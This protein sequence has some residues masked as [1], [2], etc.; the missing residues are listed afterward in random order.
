MLGRPTILLMSVGNPDF[1][2]YELS[3][4]QRMLRAAV[5]EL[6]EKEIAPHAADVDEQARFPQEALDALVQAG[7]HAVHIPEEY[8]G[9]GADAISACIVVEEVARAC[10]SSALIP[11]VNKLGTQ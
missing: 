3:D 5:R 10:G 4:E 11:A 8:G 1:H 2:Q 7:F 9:A 6:S